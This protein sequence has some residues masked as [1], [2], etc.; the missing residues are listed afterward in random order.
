MR[1]WQSIGAERGSG[2][3]CVRMNIVGKVVRS[4]LS[5]L[6]AAGAGKPGVGQGVADDKSEWQFMCKMVSR[7]F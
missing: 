6:K 5:L 2:R 4:L 3:P 1:R 7:P